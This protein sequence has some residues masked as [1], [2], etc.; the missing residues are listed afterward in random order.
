MVTYQM[1]NVGFIS[2][3]FCFFTAHAI[4]LLNFD[5]PVNVIFFKLIVFCR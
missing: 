1:R 3:Q 2:E 4:L 5:M